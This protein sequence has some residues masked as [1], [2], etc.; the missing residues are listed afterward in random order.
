MRLRAHTCIYNNDSEHLNCMLFCSVCESSIIP[1][2]TYSLHL[3]LT[4][5]AMT[6]VMN[7]VYDNCCCYFN[8]T[9]A[10]GHEINECLFVNTVIFDEPYVCTRKRA[11][12]TIGG[13]NICHVLHLTGIIVES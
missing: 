1:R 8:Y 7:D 6:T 13:P 4:H 11:L 3:K 12:E 2:S 10:I 9:L 5:R